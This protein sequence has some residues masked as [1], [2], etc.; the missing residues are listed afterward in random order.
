[1]EYAH[2]KIDH[3]FSNYSAWHSRTV[4]LPV[5]HGDSQQQR[6]GSEIAGLLAGGMVSSATAAAAAAVGED[7]GQASAETQQAQQAERENPE[8]G[9]AGGQAGSSSFAGAL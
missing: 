3:N 2:R 9:G 7:P 4:L 6:A 5:A 1:M 8:A